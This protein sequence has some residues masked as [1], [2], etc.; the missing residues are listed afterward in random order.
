M[1]QTRILVHNSTLV[2]QRLT[3]LKKQ[4]ETTILI[5]WSLE[6]STILTMLMTPSKAISSSR[7]STS[8]LIGH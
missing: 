8:Q 4:V 5:W 3:I 2:A 7:K 1:R 6:F